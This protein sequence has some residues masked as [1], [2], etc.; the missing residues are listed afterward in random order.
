[1]KL[2]P[3]IDCSPISEIEF[4]NYAVLALPIFKSDAGL[5]LGNPKAVKAIE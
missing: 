5:E 3:N 1:V 4:S 2:V